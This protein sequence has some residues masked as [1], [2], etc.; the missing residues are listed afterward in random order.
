MALVMLRYGHDSKIR[1]HATLADSTVCE[2]DIRERYGVSPVEREPI[3]EYYL[4]PG[5][6]ALGDTEIIRFGVDGINVAIKPEH[7]YALDGFGTRTFTDW[8]TTSSWTKIYTQYSILVIPTAAWG[9]LLAIARAFAKVTPDGRETLAE[10]LKDFPAG[11][12]QPRIKE[13]E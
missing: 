6:F 12:V 9:E 3:D 1:N 5:G 10:R 8:K 2:D 7:L 11:G 13:S 4:D